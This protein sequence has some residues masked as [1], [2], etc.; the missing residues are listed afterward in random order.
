MQPVS[1]KVKADYMKKKKEAEERKKRWKK[2]MSSNDAKAAKV[3]LDEYKKAHK[4]K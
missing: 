3:I 4:G 2:A 1:K